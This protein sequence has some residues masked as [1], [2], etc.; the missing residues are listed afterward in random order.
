MY[1]SVLTA[2]QAAE[3]DLEAITEDEEALIEKKQDN[4]SK[5][6]HSHDKLTGVITKHDV[7]LMSELS[8][9]I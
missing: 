9:I 6:D 3:G 7:L 4:K 8:F 5:H 2:A 1:T